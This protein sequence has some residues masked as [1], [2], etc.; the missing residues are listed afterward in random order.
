MEAFGRRDPEMADATD[1]SLVT[2]SIMYLSLCLTMMFQR[3]CLPL[4]RTLF[5]IQC[6]FRKLTNGLS[7]PV[8]SH[9]LVS[10][11][12]L[13]S[14]IST[15]PAPGRTLS[16]DTSSS[17]CQDDDEEDD[18][19]ED[20]EDEDDDQ[21]DWWTSTIRRLQENDPDFYELELD[22]SMYEEQ[23]R[24]GND[25]N[26]SLQEDV[27]TLI[28]ALQTNTAVTHLTLRNLTVTSSSHIVA[29][30]QAMPQM[31]YLQMEDTRGVGLET[32]AKIVASLATDYQQARLPLSLQHPACQRPSHSLP[33]KPI[34]LSSLVEL[35]LNHARITLP[36]AKALSLGLTP[37]SPI[38]L[39][40][41]DFQGS[42]L[43]DTS[44]IPLCKAMARNTS[45]RYWCL[46]FNSFGDLGVQAIGYMLQHNKKLQE[47]HLFGNNITAPG[48]EHLA[49][50]L[51][52]NK[53]LLSLV[54]SLNDMGDRGVAALARAL[55]HNT[56]LTKLWMP[57]NNVGNLGLQAIAQYLP[58]WQGLQELNLG[59]YFDTL[60]AQAILKALK[61][62]FV[63]RQLYLE[64]PGY[65][66]ER[67]DHEID[68]YLRLNKGGR[69]PWLRPD[70]QMVP[71]LWP[72]AL[73]RTHAYESATGSPDVLFY[74]LQQQ[75]T[76][77]EQPHHNRSIVDHTPSE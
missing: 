24:N 12:S 47:L 44:M 22:A 50:A 52:C 19:D 33:S 5:V 48:A 6:A 75:P 14:V 28:N 35:R 17:S 77:C 26:V 25:H 36:V 34:L 40:R 51:H 72:N 69:K 8:A 32:V 38:A 21:E 70:Q 37:S 56:T 20:E 9:E 57:S 3:I 41:L 27:Q 45:I 30:C 64:S 76:L 71:S 13:E 1:R 58:Q 73:A 54:L 61:H 62:N 74:L 15:P 42:H 10:E 53:S 49:R 23:H 66:C 60:A 7:F 39:E 55:S 18:V 31:T 16:S 2:R 68:F 63:L 11:L 4:V 29:L 67:T 43:N 59:D 65:D 46:D